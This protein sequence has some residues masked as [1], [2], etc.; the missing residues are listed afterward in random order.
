MLCR[1]EMAMETL[2]LTSWKCW[3]LKEN[4]RAPAARLLLESLRL[5]NQVARACEPTGVS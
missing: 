3:Q 1:T 4:T 2:E 5:T